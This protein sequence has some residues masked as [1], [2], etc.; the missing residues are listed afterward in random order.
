MQPTPIKSLDSTRE[1][2]V[3]V[4]RS[5]ISSQELPASLAN[6]GQ[7]L[8]GEGVYRITVK[9]ASQHANVYGKPQALS[10]GMQLEADVLQDQSPHH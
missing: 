4:S 1:K 5:P 2:V 8:G 9:L 7:Q 6:L 3:A 10:A